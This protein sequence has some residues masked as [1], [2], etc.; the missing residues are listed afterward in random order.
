MMM[1]LVTAGDGLAASSLAESLHQETGR[2]QGHDLRPLGLY[3]ESQWLII[4]GYLT[5]L[6]VYFGV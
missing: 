3:L 4:M 5:P 1:K 2:T 6:M